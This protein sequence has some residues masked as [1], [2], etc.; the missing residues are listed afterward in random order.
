[1]TIGN[2]LQMDGRIRACGDFEV[3]DANDRRDQ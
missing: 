1:M 2:D 3:L